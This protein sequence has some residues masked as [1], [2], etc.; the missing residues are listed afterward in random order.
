M[1]ELWR[2]LVM[3][4]VLLIRRLLSAAST[5]QTYPSGHLTRHMPRTPHTPHT[6]RI[7]DGGSFLRSVE[8]AHDC[9]S[10]SSPGTWSQRARGAISISSA[11]V[12]RED[13]AYRLSISRVGGRPRRFSRRIQ[14]GASGVW[15]D[16][17]Q[18]RSHRRALAPAYEFPQLAASLVKRNAAAIVET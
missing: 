17:R 6:R 1:A 7:I 9:T 8:K 15:M 12:W 4:A 13:P 16:R 18:E 2:K 5:H 11:S 3:S 14:G 10:Q